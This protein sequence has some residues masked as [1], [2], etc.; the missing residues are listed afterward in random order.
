[1][2]DFLEKPA[3]TESDVY[4]QAHLTMNDV[5]T[6]PFNG[7]WGVKGANLMVN[8]VWTG[9]SNWEWRVKRGCF[10]SEWCVN[11]LL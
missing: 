4:T 5:K 10:S 8:D 6:D 11:K 2:G 3:L 9:F 1:M 7:E